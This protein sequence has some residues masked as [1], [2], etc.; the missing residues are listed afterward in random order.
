M[1]R[2][3]GFLS[4]RVFFTALWLVA[5][6]GTGAAQTTPP[7]L[8]H[9]Y[10][11]FA[12]RQPTQVT[13]TLEDQFDV[14]LNKTELVRDLR[15]VRF[16]NPVQKTTADGKVTTI[17]HPDDHL[18]MYLITPEPI[19]PRVV[20][21]KNQFGTQLLR[22]ANALL[23]AVP[24]GKIWPIPGTHVFP[25]TVPTDLD[26]FK[27]YLASGKVIGRRVLLKDQFF[28]DTR[29]GVLAGVL[30]PVLFCNPVKK[31]VP[32]APPIITPITNPD[33]HLACY[34]TTRKPFNTRLLYDNQFSQDLQQLAVSNP[35]I[36]CVPSSKLRWAVVLPPR[37]LVP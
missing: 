2:V 22:T 19:I 24:S 4:A 16:C 3:T 5:L 27:C 1:K 17:Q 6:A 7:T 18:T 26:H 20:V 13:V 14:K 31:T 34:V 37:P 11:Y 9:F 21:I 8:D 23:L 10:C 35:D 33:A 30:Q 28:K 12:L 32:T 25:P 36:L 29:D 15:L